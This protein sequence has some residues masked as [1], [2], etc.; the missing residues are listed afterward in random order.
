MAGSRAGSGIDSAGW[1]DRA[2]STALASAALCTFETLLAAISGAAVHGGRMIRVCPATL[3]L[4][5]D[6]PTIVRHLLRSR[7]LHRVRQG[8]YVRDA[9]WDALEPWDRYLVRVH[10]VASTWSAPVFCL[11]SAAA[12]QGLPVFDEARDIHLLS[13]DGTTWREGDVWVH[14]SRDTRGTVDEDGFSTTTL[15]DTA[16]DLCRVLPPAFALAVAD[17]AVRGLHRNKLKFD[18]GSYG[19]SQSNRRGLRQLDWVQERA[20][21]LAESV[22]ESVSRAVIGWLGYEPPEL[23]AEFHHEGENDR[24]DFYWRRSRIVGESDGWGKY[25]SDDPQEVKAHFA[26]EKRREDRL[27]RHE[28]GFIRWDW[29]ATMKWRRLDEHLRLGGLARVRPV[30]A[31]LLATLTDNPRSLPRGRRAKAFASKRGSATPGST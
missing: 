7:T 20:T 25:D 18:F 17:N 5:K 30:Q 15:I 9:E 1:R 28:N 2:S 29:S 4:T 8:V 23:Q 3:L 21:H 26:N 27:R 14:G 16:V 10:A 11:E 13:D 6:E 12:L 24:S 31:S 19:R 22:G